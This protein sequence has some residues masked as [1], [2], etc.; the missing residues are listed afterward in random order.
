MKRSAKKFV[1]TLARRLF[2]GLVVL[3]SVLTLFF[4]IAPQGRAALQTGFFVLQVLDIPV[5]PQPWLTGDPVREEVFYPRPGSTGVA[6]V[7]RVMDG[8]PRAAVLLFLGANAAGRDDKDVVKLGDALAR[9]GFVAMFHWSPTMALQHNIDP[10]EREN[11]V[12]AFQ[13]LAAQDFVDP[14]RV[15]LGGFCVGASFSL[16]A[17]ADPRIRDEVKFV[18]AFGPYFDAEELLLQ[19]ASRS[20][21]ENGQRVPWDPD[22]LTLEVFANEL[23]DTLVDK[24]DIALLTRLHLNGGRSA[25]GELEQLSPEGQAVNR[26]LQGT[27]WEEAELLYDRLPAAFRRDMRTISPNNYVDDISAR[28]MILH[29]RDDRLV[30]AAESRR[31][32][33]A[34]EDRGDIRYT[35][36][37][38]FDHVRP[39]SGGG[40][41]Q[42]IKEG[43]KLYRHMYSIMRT[44]S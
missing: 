37:L 14:E 39:D 20:K 31:L 19:I 1:L 43:A 17:A 42:F 3:A 33:V 30:P 21:I 44:A 35:E 40:V 13:Y 10:A 8:E 7:Y 4:A 28:L 6:D 32:A 22:P 12:W 34:F 5:K 26:L 38:E 11:L 16:V 2:I 29:D 15:G 18:N 41:W 36:V 23:I 9:A 25:P 27:T 24:N